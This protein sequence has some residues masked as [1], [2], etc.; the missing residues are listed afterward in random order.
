VAGAASAGRSTGA[1]GVGTLR[2][3]VSYQDF[4][5]YQGFVRIYWWQF[6]AFPVP[7]CMKNGRLLSTQASRAA[8][9]KECH[10]RTPQP[11]ELQ[12]IYNTYKDIQS[13]CFDG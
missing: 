6:V 12:H 10:Q 2:K 1:Q 7:R 9:R 4:G 8:H 11:L 3:D 13:K 5:I